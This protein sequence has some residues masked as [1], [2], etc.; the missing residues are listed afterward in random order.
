MKKYN[1]ANS[2]ETSRN[3]QLIKAQLDANTLVILCDL[4]ISKVEAGHCPA[5]HFTSVWMGK[6]FYKFH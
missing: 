4:C 1:I 6:L 5:T 2:T 3:A